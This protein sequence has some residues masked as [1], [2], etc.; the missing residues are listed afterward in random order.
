MF[1]T[2]LSLTWLEDRS[3]PSTLDG[4]G[5]TTTPTDPTYDPTSPPAQTTPPSPTQPGDVIPPYGM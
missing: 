1:K 3:N 2:R 4:L 5:D